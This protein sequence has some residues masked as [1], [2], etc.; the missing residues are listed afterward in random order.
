MLALAVGFHGG[1]VL[2]SGLRGS[3]Y[4]LCDHGSV[5]RFEYFLRLWDEARWSF[6]HFQ[7]RGSEDVAPG[8]G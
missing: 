6:S 4:R 3:L 8:F 2:R 5:M 1:R 7:D